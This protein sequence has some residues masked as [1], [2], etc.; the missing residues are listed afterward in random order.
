MSYAYVFVR[1]LVLTQYLVGD[2]TDILFALT[3][4]AIKLAD[5]LFEHFL[6]LLFAKTTYLGRLAILLDGFGLVFALLHLAILMFS[7]RLGVVGLLDRVVVVGFAFVVVRIECTAIVV[8]F[9][10]LSFKVVVVFV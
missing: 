7:A 4:F 8:D 10:E 2:G 6:I 1:P 3:Y 9:L 5:R